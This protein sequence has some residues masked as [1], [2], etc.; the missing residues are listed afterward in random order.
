[1]VGTL[2]LFCEKC[3]QIFRA[4]EISKWSTLV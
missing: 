3:R 2:Y 4:S 1:M